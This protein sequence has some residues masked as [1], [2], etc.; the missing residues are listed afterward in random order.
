MSESV[1]LLLA[2]LFP[3]LAG[4]ALLVVRKKDDRKKMLA[5]VGVV[6]GITGVLVINALTTKETE[7]VLFELMEHVPIVLKLDGFG[8]LF[9]VIVSIVWIL[10]GCF[11]FTYMK[12]EKNEKS[13][14]YFRAILY[15]ETRQFNNG[16]RSYFVVTPESSFRR[17]ENQQ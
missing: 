4:T 16:R 5:Y 10:A 15:N 6:L 3:V 9:L 17:K 14:C 7:I 11:S 2:I 8:K 1:S 13:A 12:H